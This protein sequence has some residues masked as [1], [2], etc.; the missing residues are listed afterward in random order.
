M[1][2]DDLKS[3]PVPIEDYKSRKLTVNRIRFLEETSILKFLLN[4]FS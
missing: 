1:E 3:I 4:F 2:K